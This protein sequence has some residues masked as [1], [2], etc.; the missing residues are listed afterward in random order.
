MPFRVIKQIDF[1]Y[2]HRLL[3]YSGKCRHLHGHNGRVEIVLQGEELDQLDMLVDFGEVKRTIKDWIDAE[4][5]HKMVL[6][7]RDPLIP[8]LQEHE[9]PLYIMDCNPTAEALAREICHVASQH[10]FPVAEVRFWES[11]SS[12]AVYRVE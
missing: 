3:N 2:G 1:C 5:D 4:L 10:E 9:Q 6:N 8:L 11:P 12:T 7:R